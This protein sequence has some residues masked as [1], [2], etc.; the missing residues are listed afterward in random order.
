MATHLVLG[1]GPVGTSLATLL[2]EQGHDVVVV[3]RTG[4]AA[5]TRVAR[6]GPFRHVAADV[7]DTAA[8][9]KLAR[10]AEAVHCC[11]NPPYHRWPELWPALQTASLDAAEAV[12]AVHVMAGN[13]YPYGAGSGVMREDAPD[14][15]TETKGRVRAALWAQALERHEAGRVRAVEVRA[16]DYFGPGATGDAHAGRRLLGPVL[17]GGVLRPVGDPDQP[18]SWTYLPDFVAAMAL[19]VT[20]PEAWGRV[21]LAPT[22]GPQTYRELATGLAEA[23]GRPVPRISPLPA[24][25]LSAVSVAVPAMREVKR[26]S[27]QFTEPF[28]VDSSASQRMLGLDPTPWPDALARTVQWWQA[29]AEAA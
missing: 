5:G 11:V 17:S 23:A 24:A 12:G 2:G 25:M 7:T 4:G 28:V 1:K 16:S 29:Q 10:G 21:V 27:Y 22:A 6:S 19:A 20:T 13:L 26:V 14:A 15:T 8:L 9:T 18:H 3:S